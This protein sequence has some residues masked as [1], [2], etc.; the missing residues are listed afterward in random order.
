[1][2]YCIIK[3]IFLTNSKWQ[4]I[5]GG[6][7]ITQNSRF[8]PIIPVPRVSVSWTTASHP[9]NKT[10]VVQP[11]SGAVIP[12]VDASQSLTCIWINLDL[13]KCRFCFINLVWDP[14]ICILTQ[15][16]CWCSLSTDHTLG[17]NLGNSPGRIGAVERQ[18]LESLA[19]DSCVEADVV[20]IT[21]GQKGPLVLDGPALQ[22][23]QAGE[24]VSF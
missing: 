7:F 16:W 14:W 8:F 13:V 11:S 15:K 1:M 2:T 12:Q 6:S 20:P 24:D 19:K 10:R 5:T 22:A 3:L 4:D 18:I 21:G 9:V 17:N 23:G